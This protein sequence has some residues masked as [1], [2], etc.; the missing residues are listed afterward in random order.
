MQKVVGN[1]AGAT[2]TIVAPKE[3]RSHERRITIMLSSLLLG[4]SLSA[5]CGMRVFLP[6]LALSGAAR[7]EY[8]ALSPGFAW[9]GSLPA[10]IVIAACAAVELASYHVPRARRSV[11]MVSTPAAMVVGTLLTAAVLS[12]ASPVVGLVVP[13]FAGGGIAGLSQSLFSFLPTAPAVAAGSAVAVA[14]LALVFPVPA[15]SL[16]IAYFVVRWKKLGQAVAR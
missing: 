12:D 5:A 3:P 14:L 11:D 7:L 13:L 1:F 10:V 16:V 4:I 9:L 8:V 6:A 15:G 2:A